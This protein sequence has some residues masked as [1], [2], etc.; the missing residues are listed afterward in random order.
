MIVRDIKNAGASYEYVPVG[1]IDDDWRKVGRRIHGVEVLGRKEDLETVL[2][3]INPQEIVIAIPS[4]RPAVIRELVKALQ[5]FKMPLRTLPGLRDLRNGR[6]GVNQIRDLSLEDLL[7]RT[8][9]GLDLVP[10]R[11]L[12]KGKRILI[13]GAGGSIGSELSR[14]IA[15]H[16][17]ARLILLDQSE[18]ALYD[19]SMELKRSWPESNRTAVLADIKNGRALEQTFS[20]HAPEIIFHAAAYKHVPMLE[21]HPGEA[22]LNNIVGTHRLVQTA[23]RHNVDR[24]VQISTDKAVNPTNVMGATKRVAE[25][26][27]H[28]LARSSGD[29]GTIFSAV[30]FGNVLGS[31]GSVVPLF[32][33]QIEQG[34]PVTVTHP[35]IQR[36]FMTIPEAVLLVLQAATLAR[37]GEIFVLD[38]GEQ[39]KLIDMARNMIRL[40]GFVP[41]EEIPVTVIGLRPGEKLREELAASDETLVRSEVEKILRVESLHTPELDSLVQKISELEQLASIG[42]TEPL[43]EWLYQVVP[44]FRPLN[45]E[46][47]NQISQRRA[48]REPSKLWRVGRHG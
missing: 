25:L 47:A 36:Y 19:I 18:S 31:N 11:N 37:G 32:M 16:E 8:P 27:M 29:G 46:I 21:E 35:D 17:P 40:A 15:K 7:D 39:I 26:Y 33:K 38:M 5:P 14:Q 24:F 6:V 3:A 2:A 42:K 13:T 10:V 12:I 23:I 41:D 44:T 9:V 43:I 22:V 30:R 4:A 1:F 45:A 28:A 34:G 48:K 20:E